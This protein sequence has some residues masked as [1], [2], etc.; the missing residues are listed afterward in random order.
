M[1]PDIFSIIANASN[2]RTG[3]NPIYTSANFLEAYPQFAG[4]VPE[5]VIDAWVKLANASILEPRWGDFWEAA[6]DLYVAHFLTLYLQSSS[7]V[8]DATKKIINAGLSKGLQSSKSASDLSVSYDFS[9][10]AN[11]TAGWGTFPQTTFGQQFVQF[12]KLVGRG[13]MTIW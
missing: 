8:G 2:I 10:V 9:S 5:V 13:G 11:E 3:D 6:I 4:A 1:G 7:A 12:A